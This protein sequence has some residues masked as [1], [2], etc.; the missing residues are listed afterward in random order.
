MKKLFPSKLI[1]HKSEHGFVTL[2]VLVALLTATGFVIL[3]LQFFV[4]AMA[5]KVQAQEKQR[6]NQLIQEDIERLNELGSTLV[7]GAA[8]AAPTCDATAYANSF[9]QALWVALPGGIQTKNVLENVDQS[10]GSLD[11]NGKQLALQRFHVSG[12]ANNSAAPHK[13]LKVRY[14][15]WDWNGAY[16]NRV[17]AALTATDEPIAETYVEIIPDVALQCP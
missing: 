13:T 4:G 2:E 15:V 10:D 3:S 5:I 9:A 16:V 12:T 14:Q 6:A 8:G 1:R 7:G 11:T 17:G